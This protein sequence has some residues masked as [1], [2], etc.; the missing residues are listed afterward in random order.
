MRVCD[1]TGRTKGWR[2]VGG[3]IELGERAADAV[4]REIKEELDVTPASV[5]FKA[6]LENIY[7]HE[8]VKGHELV[9]VHDVEL[10]PSASARDEYRFTD[11]GVDVDVQW[12]ALDEFRAGRSELF[13]SGLLRLVT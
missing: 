1:D 3:A 6:V 12:V 9:M 2:P 8:G 11:G 5:R 4:A 7:E 13:P 10:A